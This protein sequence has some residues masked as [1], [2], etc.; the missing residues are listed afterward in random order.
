MT[1][2]PP[3]RFARALMLILL[4]VGLALAVPTSPADAASYP[5]YGQSGSKV[6]A[7]QN[8]LIAA[9]YLKAE[10]NGGSFGQPDQ[11][12]DQAG[13][14]QVRPV[15]HRQAQRQDDEPRSTRR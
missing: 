11:G 14:A 3:R 1:L 8:K 2:A 10:L 7:V 5:K 12:R 4:I 9:G 6:R 15:R 13:A